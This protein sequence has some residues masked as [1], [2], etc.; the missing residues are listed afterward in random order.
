[1]PESP[2]VFFPTAFPSGGG[3]SPGYV[4]GARTSLSRFDFTFTFLRTVP[5]VIEG[6]AERHEVVSQLTMS[7]RY[8]KALAE[9][10]W[11][12]IDRYEEEFGLIEPSVSPEEEGQDGE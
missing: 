12:N 3:A 10:L 1:M 5:P 11:D 6:D 8:A 9:L 7:P 2:P 4:N